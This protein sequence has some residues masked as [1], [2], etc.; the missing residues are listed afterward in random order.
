MSHYDDRPEDLAQD[1]K[2]FLKSDYGKYLIS[3]LQEMAKG[4][5]TSTADIRIEHPER[6]AA[7]YSALKEALD[8]IYQPLDDDTPSLG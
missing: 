2:S 3:T 5:L 7:K 6:Y 1:T 4:Y 8:L